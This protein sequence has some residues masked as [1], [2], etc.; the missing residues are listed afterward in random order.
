MFN[1]F[2]IDGTIVAFKIV[3]V[4]CQIS[5]FD[6]SLNSIINNHN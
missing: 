1:I 6:E 3:N 4:I 2:I 5:S